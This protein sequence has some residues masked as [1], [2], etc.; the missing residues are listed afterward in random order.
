[1]I[2]IKETAATT[3]PIKHELNNLP[4]EEILR[5]AEDGVRFSIND[6]YILNATKE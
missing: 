1:M 3:Q 4:C 2:T 5:M 6:G